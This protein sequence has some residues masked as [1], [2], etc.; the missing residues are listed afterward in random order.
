Y[1]P[2]RHHQTAE[3][4][5]A[6]HDHRNSSRNGQLPKTHP[7]KQN[8]ANRQHVFQA[9]HHDLIDPQS[10]QRPP[11]PHHDKHQ[12]E[13]LEDEDQDVDEVADDRT[14]QIAQ[15]ARHQAR[16]PATQEQHGGDAADGE[17]GAILGHEED[18]PAEAAILG[19]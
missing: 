11:H 5:Q 3:H 7:Q 12:H 6:L 10:R 19:V 9:S 8:A 15:F 17:H 14:Q 13:S 2:Y 18:Q 1:S 4:Q 16:V